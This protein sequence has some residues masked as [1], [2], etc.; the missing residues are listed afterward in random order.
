MREPFRS[1]ADIARER[2][3]LDARRRHHGQ[4]LQQHYGA[5]R[6]PA[7]RRK[8]LWSSV[9]SLFPRDLGTWK[10]LFT[11]GGSM[12]ASGFARGSRSGGGRLFWLG[13]S[14][15]LPFLLKRTDPENLR[16]M[17]HEVGNSFDRVR[18]YFRKRKEEREARRAEQA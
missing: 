11:T 3:R 9:K 7:R 17:A 6:D 16:N 13:L 1:L 4:R 10:D 12:A 14:F 18:D 8:M 5:F 2:E 15:A